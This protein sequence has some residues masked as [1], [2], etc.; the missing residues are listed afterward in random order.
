DAP[1]PKDGPLMRFYTRLVCSSVRHRWITLA[2]GLI[3]FMGSI[4]ST[5]LLPSGF[6]PAD[7]LARTLLAVELPPGSR[8]VDTDR[9]TRAIPQRRKSRAAVRSVIVYGGQ[10]LGGMGGAGEVRRATL[11]INL[12]HKSERAM[13][14]KELQKL[15]GLDLT[16]VPDVR[17]WFLKDNGQ[18]DISLIIAGNELDQ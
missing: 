6:I 10:L 4:A 16:S 9:G 8:L 15:I 7:D 12:V 17:F 11:V 1:P 13:T 2:L 5:K 18:R 3:L 14:Q